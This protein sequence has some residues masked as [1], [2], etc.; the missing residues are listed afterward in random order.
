MPVVVTVFGVVSDVIKGLMPVVEIVFGV[1]ESV[2]RGAMTA[3]TGIIQIATGLISGDWSMVWEGIQNVF[4]GIWEGIG[5][6]L[7]GALDLVVSLFTNIIPTL[8]DAGADLINGLLGGIASVAGNIAEAILGPIR[9]AVDG[10]KSFLGIKSPSRL[11]MQIGAFTG[12]GMAIG[13]Q[14]SAGLIEDASEALIPTV[15]TV[16]APSVQAGGV[17]GVIASAVAAKGDSY[18]VEYNDYSTSTEDK[19]AKLLRA[20][21]ALEQRHAARRGK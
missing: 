8:W 2:I 17:A 3:I 10:V 14:K 18:S 5:G 20:Q 1:V 15:P 19:Q 6:I 11:F 13:L 21:T 12:E 16:S 9:G 7:K 4:S